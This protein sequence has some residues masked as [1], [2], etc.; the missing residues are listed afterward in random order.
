M[1]SRFLSVIGMDTRTYF[2]LV[3]TSFRSSLLR[4]QKRVGTTN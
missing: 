1:L 2:W 4:P 3:S